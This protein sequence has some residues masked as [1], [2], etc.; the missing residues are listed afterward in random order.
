MPD[1][2]VFFCGIFTVRFPHGNDRFWPVITVPGYI[3]NCG[4]WG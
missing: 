4:S 2:N 3:N 1:L